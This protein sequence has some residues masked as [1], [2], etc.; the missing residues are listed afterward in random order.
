MSMAFFAYHVSVDL[1]KF[2]TLCAILSKQF[3]LLRKGI[4]GERKYTAGNVGS[5]EGFLT[6]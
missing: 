2:S 4:E 6:G 1:A 5:R 3:P